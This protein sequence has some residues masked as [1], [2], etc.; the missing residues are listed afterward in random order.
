MTKRIEHGAEGIANNKQRRIQHRAKGIGNDKDQVPV[1]KS[2]KSQ[3]NSPLI[4]FGVKE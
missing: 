2:Q 1:T 4:T 3:A